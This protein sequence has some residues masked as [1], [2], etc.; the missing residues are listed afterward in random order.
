MGEPIMKKIKRI[1]SCVALGLALITATACGSQQAAVD[2]KTVN[3]ESA[4]KMP[5]FTSE[6]IAD[7]YAV[8]NTNSGLSKCASMVLKHQL[9]LKISSTL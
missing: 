5:N 2:A 8:F 4:N 9:Q 7:E 6:P 1:F 3:A